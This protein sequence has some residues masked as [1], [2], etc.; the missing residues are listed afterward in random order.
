MTGKELDYVRGAI[1]NEGFDYAFRSYSD[2]A[3]VKDRKF[4][5]LRKAYVKA[6][7]ALDQYVGS[8]EEA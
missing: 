3:E 2:F 7:E 5:S 8:G 1:D 4:H 6:A